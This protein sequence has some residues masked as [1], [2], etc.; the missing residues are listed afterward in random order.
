MN[1]AGFV[2]FIKTPKGGELVVLPRTEYEKL[3]RAASEESADVRAYDTAKRRLAAGED[4]L[5]PAE[6]ADRLLDG[7]NPVRVWRE[8]RGLSIRELAGKVGITAAYLSQIETGVR[9]GKVSTVKALADSLGVT[10]DDLI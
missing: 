4:E 8:Y 6:F 2:Q 10:V 9:E 3:R 5:I 1:K 7:E